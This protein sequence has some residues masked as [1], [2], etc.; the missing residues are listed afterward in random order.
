MAIRHYEGLHIKPDYRTII[1][2]YLYHQTCSFVLVHGKSM[3]VR[4]F[5]LCRCETENGTNKSIRKLSSAAVKQVS[6]W[7][8]KL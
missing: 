6:C 7:R 1:I 3:F 2:Y 4:Q 5:N 8:A